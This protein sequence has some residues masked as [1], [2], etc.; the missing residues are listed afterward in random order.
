MSGG[1][2]EER[3]GEWFDERTMNAALAPDLR[4]AGLHTLLYAAISAAG[5]H[6]RP[7]QVNNET[8]QAAFE[9]NARIV[10]A[11]GGFSTIS[12]SGILSNLANKAMLDAYNAVAAVAGRFCSEVDHSDFKQHT[13]YRM[14]GV[15]AFESVAP[16][17]EISHV[18]L[19][20]TTYTNQV[21]TKGALIALTRQMMINDDLGAFL[22]IPRIIGRMSAIAKEKAVFTLLLANT[23]SFFHA[24]NSNLNTGAGSALGIDSLTTAEQTMADQTDAN[25]DPILIAAAFLLTGTALKVY[26]QQLFKD[27]NVNETTTA[28]KPK[29]ASNP[30]A[31]KFEP[32]SSPYVNAQGLTGSSATLWYLFANPGDVAAMEIAY[33]RGRR[34]PVIESADTDFATLGM[35]W[36]GYFDFGV[37]FQDPRAAVQNNGA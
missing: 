5:G 12:L 27:L 8:I 29:P 4:G 22:Q 28:N 18:T 24:A 16:N 35:Q 33:L 6:V 30:H 20:E 32:L 3:V 10:G 7:G 14:T 11:A 31:G 36:R 37:N 17:G 19:G 25:G 2:S 26:A 23:G 13:K 21:D 1:L 9:A 34:V 15:G